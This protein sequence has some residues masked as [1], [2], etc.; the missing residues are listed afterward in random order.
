MPLDPRWFTTPVGAVIG[1]AI[2]K[3]IYRD[4]T[5]LQLLTGGGLG[6]LTGFAGGTYMKHHLPAYAGDV[7]KERASVEKARAEA[8]G[9][10]VK[11][12]EDD[13]EL[14]AYVLASGRK[15]PQGAANA[16]ELKLLARNGGKGF[17]GRALGTD[18]EVSP[19]TYDKVLDYG[20]LYRYVNPQIRQD[21]DVS[22]LRQAIL[23]ILERK[24]AEIRANL[25][26]EDYAK[27][28]TDKAAIG[29]LREFPESTGARLYRLTHNVADFMNSA[30][31][32]P[33]VALL[34]AIWNKSM[35]GT[36]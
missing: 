17:K 26:P 7:A 10:T 15:M 22:A 28:Q 27:F 20:I 6:G 29:T 21:R 31:Q 24:D 34:R 32:V 12:S 16:A 36:K 2:T 11:A 30:P 8:A 1:A 14:N 18:I 3:A 33:L 35:A 25:S 13:P 5:R 19:S 9:T 23:P 4:P